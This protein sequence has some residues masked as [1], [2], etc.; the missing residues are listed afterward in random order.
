MKRNDFTIIELLLVVA[1]AGVLLAVAV[2]SFSRILKGTGP[3]RAARE[4]IGKL[5]AAR[6][7]AVSNKTDVAIIFP[8]DELASITNQLGYQSYRVCEVYI[9][10]NGTITFKRWVPGEN[11][12]YLPSGVLIG[13]DKNNNN[14]LFFKPG[15]DSDEK[16][17]TTTQSAKTVTLVEDANARPAIPSG[18]DFNN[19]IIFRSDGMLLAMQ[20][21]LIKIREARKEGNSLRPA[22]LDYLPLVV[23]F[24]GKVKAFN[25]VVSE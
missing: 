20:P 18:T 8:Q 4:L 16:T 3:T 7:Y 12:N 24:N 5:N 10:S 25:E 15:D 1:I 22:N 9:Q 2:P 11:W 23:R 6:A 21:V 13:K 19:G 14:E 17:A